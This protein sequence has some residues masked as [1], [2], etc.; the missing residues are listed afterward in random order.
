LALDELK[1][2]DEKYEF[3]GFTIVVEKDLLE[4]TGGMCIEFMQ[5]P[6]GGGFRIVPKQPITGA[7]Q[8]GDACGGC[9]C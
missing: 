8:A 4:S 5:N 1:D 7:G 2:T 6:F 3:D 9:S